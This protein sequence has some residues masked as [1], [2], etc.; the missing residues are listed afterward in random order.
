MGQKLGRL[1]GDRAWTKA[2]SYFDGTITS[3]APTIEPNPVQTT[4]AGSR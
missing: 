3:P 2:R 4:R 1:V